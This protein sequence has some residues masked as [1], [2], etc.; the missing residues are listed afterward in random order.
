MPIHHFIS[1][2]TVD[3]LD[4]ALKLHD[5]LEA[6]P[7]PISVWLDKRHLAP[8][9]DWDEQLAGAIRDCESLIFV[10]TPD[11]IE[12][13]STCK[14]E[15]T[16]AL[17]YK[18]PIVPVRLHRNAMLP[19]RLEPRQYID[20]TG[21]FEAGM[22]RLRNHLQWLSSP[23]GTLQAMK[24]RLADAQRDLRRA[25]DAD[26]PRIQDDIDLL[27]RQ[28]ADQE[29]IVAD[30]GAAVR[31]VEQSIA[32]GL[33]RE[34]QPERPVAGKAVT[35]FIN[36]P[37]GVAP[38]Y[39][40][41]RVVENQV[42]ANFL[43]DESCRLMTVVGRAG[44]GKTALVCR[45]LKALEAGHL[46]DD[47]GPLVADG[48][49]YLSAAGSRRVN[50]PNLFADLCKLLPG[51]AAAELDALYRNPQV[52]TD[53]KIR[54]LLAAFPG[55]KPQGI[56][57]TTGVVLLLDNFEDIVDPETQEIRDAEMDEALIALLNAPHHAIKAILTTRV[58]PRDLALIQPGR[59]CRL[60]LDDG[61]GSPFAEN[62]L[63]E[64]DRDG[65]VGLKRAPAA[66]LDRARQRTRGYPR[67]LEALFA[68]LSAD[69]YTG[70]NEILDKAEQYLPEN[71]VE[72]LVGEAFVRLDPTGQRV[73]QALAVYA[74]PVT[75]AAVDF[76]L[77]P[78]LPGLDSAAVLGRLVNMHFARRE[79]GKYYLHPVDRAY[80]FDRIPKDEKPDESG[81]DAGIDSSG[82][83]HAAAG[84]QAWE[85]ALLSN[86]IVSGFPP[87]EIGRGA[88]GKGRPPYTQ[89]AL[90][91]R[92]ADYFRQ[93]RKPRADWKTLD[94]LGPQ[95][96]EF[97]L[98]CAAGEYD[99]AGWVLR[100]IDFDHLFLWGHYR[101]M[102]E[103]HEQLQ[104]KLNDSWLKSR[105]V[106]NLGSVHFFIG[107]F[108]KAITCYEQALAI[109]R[110]RRDRQSEGAWLGN[111]G[112]CYLNLGQTARAI[113]Y[114]EQALTI[115][116]EIGDRRGEGDGLGNL[117][118]CYFRMGQI[119]H[120]IEY[121]EQA[122]AIDR[123]IGYRKGEGQDFG[124]LGN[125]Y[126]NLGQT[127]RAIEYSE[128]AL[129]I[130]RE[131]GDRQGE[132]HRLGNLADALTDA[133][134]YAEAIQR[135]GESVKIGEE[136]GSPVISNDPGRA[137]ALAH[138]CAGDL[139]AARAAAEAAR[140]YDDPQNNHN[141]LALLGVIALRQ[142][143]QS[144]ARE[145]LAAA[146][147]AAD[148]ILAQTPQFFDALDAK[149]LACCGL[150]LC[151]K[152]GAGLAPAQDTRAGARPAPTHLDAAMAAYRAARAVNRD[153]GIVARVL[154]LLD[155]LAA[156][157]PEGAAILAPARATAAGE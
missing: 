64:M 100:E 13:H 134:R 127:A 120:A 78:V 43:K 95:L 133:G 47:L 121:H 123:E 40:Q 85:P 88:G 55:P 97:D 24:D 4:F 34:R 102:A 90:L 72:A 19:F 8:G 28:I 107:Q 50:F 53:A 154:R 148:A 118:N 26:Q 138:L 99:T 52:S 135:A 142:G 93:A 67:A 132:G 147:A 111:L 146:V 54:A 29:R 65:K 66:L 149:G 56:A 60:D 2:S 109:S 20:F 91:R 44:I 45:L 38:G 14:Q 81:V 128:Q 119:A 116:R 150:A 1:Y 17:K 80:A 96:A 51:A 153:A 89:F 92:A 122:L 33:E 68:I 86:R 75:P 32:A 61:L 27:T 23:A 63:R 129:A 115:F 77:Q 113:E 145:A 82:G 5:E 87:P 18:K 131:I 48:I 130:A 39:F 62:I 124:N 42:V 137:L 12:D 108:Q 110:D 152:V 15:W 105:S 101:L 31:R 157:H 69:R 21:S 76:V 104:G 136:I 140:R 30:P 36:P 98:R 3:A 59:Q 9:L 103:L 57:P 143:D 94:D 139:P 10:M 70:L 84:P 25:S 156:A 126:A 41:D 7:P 141:V 35:K 46:P 58:A 125:C 6:G 22:A 11:S 112:N 114:T 37:P 117:G 151:D 144:A 74:R 155:A 79:A 49:V 71:V 106:G 16:H 83:S 73:M